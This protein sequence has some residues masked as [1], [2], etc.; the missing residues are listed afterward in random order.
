MFVAVVLE[1]SQG[2]RYFHI[3]FRQMRVNIMGLN[4]DV[5]MGYN[6]K[7]IQERGR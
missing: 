2:S 6:I 4:V 5:Y 1:R 3:I 7:G